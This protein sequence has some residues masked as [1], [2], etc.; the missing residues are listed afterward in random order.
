MKLLEIKGDIVVINIDLNVLKNCYRSEDEYK[1][2]AD[3]I[4]NG[5]KEFINKALEKIKRRLINEGC[6]DYDAYWRKNK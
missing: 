6:A 3:K 4:R 1:F 5:N 2:V